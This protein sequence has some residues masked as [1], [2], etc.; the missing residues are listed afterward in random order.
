[1][2]DTAALHP[3]DAATSFTAGS[4]GSLA[5]T[6]SPAYWNMVG[7]FGGITAAQLLKAAMDHPARIGEPVAQTVNFCAPIAEGAFAVRVKEV[8]SGRSVQ[9]LYAELVQGE[10]IAAN[11]TM[12][13]AR[14]TETWRHHASVMP[15]APPPD[16][17]PVLGRKPPLAWLDAYEFRYISGLPI[18]G[19]E[20]HATPQAAQS[21]LWVADQ[22]PRPLDHVA[23]A[24]LCDI[25]IVRVFQ[26]RGLRIPAATVSMTS[27]FHADAAELAEQGSRPVLAR[28]DS[29]RFGDQFHDQQAELWSAAGRLL[30]TTTQVVWFRE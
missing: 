9:H 3:F 16:A 2:S 10:T 5:G 8:R 29:I 26:V 18:M 24:S 25:F 13:F 1:M 23:L 12:V 22:P 7:P 20:A 6:T 4:D 19:S 14:R 21:L 11:A 27:Y 30:A 17:V 28:A 15:V